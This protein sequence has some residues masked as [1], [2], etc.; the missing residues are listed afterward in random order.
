MGLDFM[1]KR[2]KSQKYYDF[3][4]TIAGGMLEQLKNYDNKYKFKYSSFLAHLILHQNFE[5]LEKSMPVSRFD[6]KG[7]Y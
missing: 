5:L 6:V 3:F 4:D 7:C 2:A 1:L